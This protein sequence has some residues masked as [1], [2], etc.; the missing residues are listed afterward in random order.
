VAGDTDVPFGDDFSIVTYSIY[1]DLL[2]LS[3]LASI[4]C[5]KRLLISGQI[6][7]AA[8]WPLLYS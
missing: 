2:W 1:F 4:H 8:K 3:G 7:Y 5:K 6:F